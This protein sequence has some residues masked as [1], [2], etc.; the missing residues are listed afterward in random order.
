MV[1]SGSTSVFVQFGN[2][3]TRAT[4]VNGRHFNAALAACGDELVVKD[5][6]GD[7]IVPSKGATWSDVAASVRD[8]K[9]V[10]A[11]VGARKRKTAIAA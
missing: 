11:S 3:K 7:V 9:K 10:Q 5:G 4:R 2:C 6:S 8:G 1:I